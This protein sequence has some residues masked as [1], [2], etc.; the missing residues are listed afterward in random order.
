LYSVTNKNKKQV[1]YVQTIPEM[2]IELMG[3]GLKDAKLLVFRGEALHFRDFS[4]EELARL[5][6]ELSGLEEQL[7]IV[8]KRGLNLSALL[9]QAGEKGLPVY[10]VVLA[11]KEHWFYTPAQV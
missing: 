6:Q 8:E 7:I 2:N 4:G 5:V 1:R 11:G 10:H 9:A 3:R